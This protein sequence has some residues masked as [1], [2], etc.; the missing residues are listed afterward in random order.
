MACNVLVQVGTV[1]G[2]GHEG[3]KK[4]LFV[5][6]VD[7]AKRFKAHSSQFSLIQTDWICL[8]VVQMPRSQD[9][10]IFVPTTTTMTDIQTD[11]HYPLYM[12]M[13]HWSI[14]LL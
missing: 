8:Q 14:L 7:R 12:C 2:R 3:Q 6:F 10:A 13:G 11:L 9:L 4:T 5:M 1:D